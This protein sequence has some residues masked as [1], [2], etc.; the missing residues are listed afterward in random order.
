MKWLQ[1]I[2]NA[3]L[4]MFKWCMARRRR[5]TLTA[6]GKANS[7]TADGPLYLLFAFVYGVLEWSESSNFLL[8]F[9]SAF[10]VE[11]IIYFVVKNSF[12]RN[13]PQETIDNFTSFIVPS[14]QFSLPSGHTSAA[15]L[16]ALFVGLQFTLLLPWLLLWAVSVAFSRIF[17]GVHFPTD[18]LLGALL[19]SSVALTAL[20]FGG[21]I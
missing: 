11:R 15:F 20:Y 16:F 7:K 14:D 6:L 12:K 18:T 17:L 13:R 9:A 10:L 2:Q 5:A 1:P 3:D 4:A 19:G 21:L 8:W